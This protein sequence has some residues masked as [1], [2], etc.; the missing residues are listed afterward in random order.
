MK[1]L[2][3]GQCLQTDS[4][5]RGIGRYTTG[6]IFGLVRE[7]VDVTVLLNG[8]L[9]TE[10]GEAINLLHGFKNVEFFYPLNARDKFGTG[11]MGMFLSEQLYM[12]SVFKINPD[13]YICASLFEIGQNFVCPPIERLVKQFRVVTIN[14]DL[15]P[16]EDYQFFLTNKNLYES[17][18]IALRRLVT[19]DVVFCISKY[20]EKQLQ[21]LYPGVCTRVIWGASF[22]EKISDIK[23]GKYIF[24]CGGLDRR[25]NVLFLVKAYAL[26]PNDIRCEHNL[27]ICCR[28]GREYNEL[29]NK[30][31]QWKLKEQVKL[32][33][34][35]TN[36]SLAR[37]YAESK[38]FVFPSLAEGL[39]LPLIEALS[40]G[41][42][43]LTSRSSSL[44]EIIDNKEA[45]FDPENEQ[46]LKEKLYKALTDGKYFD[47]LADYSKINNHKFTWDRTA[48]LC[49]NVFCEL[50]ETIDKKKTFCSNIQTLTIPSDLKN[51][52]NI[53][54]IRQNTVIIFFSVDVE[55]NIGNGDEAKLA[56]YVCKLCR[57][58]NIVVLFFDKRVGDKDKNGYINIYNNSWQYC[59]KLKL[60]YGDCIC[61][62]TNECGKI[63]YNLVNYPDDNS[64]KFNNCCELLNDIVANHTTT[65]KKCLC[66]NI[67]ISAR[68]RKESQ[69]KLL[70][71][72]VLSKYSLTKKMRKKYSEKLLKMYDLS[73]VKVD[74]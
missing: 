12:E 69:F 33:E 46:D 2:V 57:Q 42:P 68:D 25:K 22:D 44:I 50:V 36:S 63:I 45:W 47:K 74:F 26:L 20:V 13:L 55:N 43:I 70:E 65:L 16:L 72:K 56:D 30:I 14:Y 49:M 48:R 73:T 62:I 39:G 17:Y 40:F 35:K 52:Y 23:K 8:S 1:I 10:I 41:T 6:L 59:G 31:N 19:A 37:L 67:A 28:K 54:K 24:Y 5:Y 71:Y 61:Y 9:E 18:L 32:V 38:L 11:G 34:A 3:D 53:S 21:S 60:M 7:G 27:L 29:L 66:R 58:K 15:I 51:L 4:R 64:V